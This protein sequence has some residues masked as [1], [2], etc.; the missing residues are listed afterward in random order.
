MYAQLGTIVF[1][2]LKG[3]ESLSDKRETQYVEHPLIKGKPLLQK[4]GE[5][6]ITISGSISFHVGFCNPEDEYKKLNDARV[7]GD[8]LP[9]IY[10]NSFIEG[11]FVIT[12]LE[13]TINQTDKVGNF[14]SI[15]CNL[16][17]KEF[18]SLNNTNIQQERDKANAFAISANRPLPANPN[19]QPAN[20]SLAVAN[21]TS[22]TSKA[23]DVVNSETD[24]LNKTVN[25]AN[26]APP[27]SKA[28]AFV[29]QI[30]S[31]T[32][33]INSQLTT[34]QTSLAQLTN[35]L[36]LYSSL[37][38]LSPDLATTVTNANSSISALQAQNSIIASL[39]NPVTTT[40]NAITALNE[41]L[42]TTNLVLAFAQTIKDLKTANSK[43]AIA[44]ATKKVIT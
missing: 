32:Q 17:L 34:A 28:Q 13:R 42:I 21:S 8:V 9:F 11:D 29:D 37:G 43:V 1:E 12:T 15:S 26:S 30:P 25:N 38:V 27:I 10:G 36:S 40:P 16:E 2:A 14:V 39:P 44:L 33:K 7:N 35:L 24:K 6:L 20:P 31:Y 4:V 22:T 23:G 18:I 41:L 5:S 19:T 3:F